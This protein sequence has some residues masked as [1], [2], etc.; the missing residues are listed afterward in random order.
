M[1]YNT[2]LASGTFFFTLFDVYI[3]YVSAL[4]DSIF[5]RRKWVDKEKHG[6]VPV[7]GKFLVLVNGDSSR[8]SLG[9]NY[10]LYYN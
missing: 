3:F 9:G 4:R 5:Q 8:G 6:G 2:A 7:Q 10:G 1:A